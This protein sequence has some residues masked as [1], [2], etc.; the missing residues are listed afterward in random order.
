MIGVRKIFCRGRGFGFTLIELLVVIAV[1]AVLLGMTICVG[2]RKFDRWAKDL[3]ML[4]FVA[5]RD[6][7]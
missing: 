7:V 1:I 2:L 6:F 3:P 5:I 4:R